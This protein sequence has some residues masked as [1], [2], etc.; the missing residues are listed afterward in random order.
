MRLCGCRTRLDL[1]INA[2]GCFCVYWILGCALAFRF[3]SK[4][5]YRDCM[6]RS[7]KLFFQRAPND[8]GFSWRYFPAMRSIVWKRSQG[9]AASH[10]SS[11][12]AIA[13]LWIEWISREIRCVA[14]PTRLRV[15]SSPAISFFLFRRKLK[16]T[17]QLPRLFRGQAASQLIT[18]NLSGLLGH[19]IWFLNLSLAF[20]G[21]FVI[22]DRRF[23]DR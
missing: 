10:D 19:K 21:I 14:A 6:T 17:S 5:T 13:F 9:T 15:P 1:R 8:S 18:L 7:C 22:I 12:H 3:L 4:S 2:S 23:R 20:I 11:G 16:H